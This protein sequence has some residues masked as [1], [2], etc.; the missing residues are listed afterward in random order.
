MK[1]LSSAEGFFNQSKLFESLAIE[2]FDI[3]K[4]IDSQVLVQYE[5]ATVQEKTA[6]INHQEY[7]LSTFDSVEEMFRCENL[8]IKH[9]YDPVFLTLEGAYLETVAAVSELYDISENVLDD[10]WSGT[11]DFF[12]SGR[13]LSLVKSFLSTMTEGG[14]AIGILQFVLDIIG[15]IPVGELTLGTIPLNQAANIINALISFY[16]EHYILGIISLGMGIPA[17]GQIVFAP[18]KLITKP[19]AGILGKFGEAI[20]KGE[21]ASIR[22]ATSEFKAGAIAIDPAAKGS[23]GVITMLGNGLKSIATYVGEVGLKVVGG[24]VDFIGTIINKVSL[25]LIP[26]PA[27]LSRWIEEL[28]VKMGAFSKN[29]AEAGEL[30]LKDEAKVVAAADKA[31]ASAEASALSSGVGPLNASQ[32]AKKFKNVPGFTDDIVRQIADWDKGYAKL[33][34]AEASESVKSMYLTYATTERLVGNI[35]A[36]EGQMF[37]RSLLDV[38]KNPGIARELERA[39][40]RGV[41]KI[42]VDSIKSGN[43]GAVAQTLQSIIDN[44]AAMKYLDKDIAK[45]VALF[46]EAPELLVKGPAALKKAQRAMTQLASL[47]GKKAYVGVSTKALI[48]FFLKFGVKSSDC[49][50]QIGKGDSVD[51]VFNNV[52]NAASDTESS[53]ATKAVA[54]IEPDQVANLITEEAD[55]DAIAVEIT[56]DDLE[57]FRTE[58]PE[59]YQALAD[60]VKSSKEKIK[61][62]ADKTKPAN[63]CS[64]EASMSEA[65]TGSMIDS[66]EIVSQT[67]LYQQKG[68]GDV[69]D[70]DTEEE[71]EALMKPVESVLKMLNQDSDLSP[72]HSLTSMDPY[73]RAY[74]SDSWD[75]SSGTIRPNISGKSRLDSTLDEMEKEGALSASQ[76][77]EVREA[78]LKHWAEDTMPEELENFSDFPAEKVQERRS[79]PFQIGTVGSLRIG[80]LIA[81]R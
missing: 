70:V 24:L 37:N 10:L 29:A 2:P 23:T 27:G 36:K 21:A 79:M 26:K 65:V 63:P 4:R 57:K 38:L 62:I 48:A 77:D 53:L 20:W 78:T 19:F 67:G 9:G 42:L 58:N 22:A 7:L 60:Q 32:I 75:Y 56:K 49:L 40:F 31:A 17:V 51:D 15:M 47:G 28:S 73:T 5:A 43:S 61:E 8:L 35:L 13:P 16:R 76:R 50:M 25:G 69:T 12:T 14:S 46:R 59:A 34:K 6:I 33:I 68:G 52:S 1:Y 30:L 45:T 55:E 54:E 41:D 39:G 11:K 44:P 72:Q 18:L 3:W 66:E 64:L 81:I 74:F 71:K 80:K